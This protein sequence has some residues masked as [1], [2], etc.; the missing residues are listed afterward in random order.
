MA[1]TK[2]DPEAGT[3]SVNVADFQRTRDSV[4]SQCP[5]H[6]YQHLHLNIVWPALQLYYTEL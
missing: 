3:V 4:S 6:L 2:S 5:N 1:K